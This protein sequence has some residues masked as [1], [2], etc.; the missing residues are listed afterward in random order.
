M[1]CPDCN[2]ELKYKMTVRIP[3]IKIL[4]LYLCSKCNRMKHNSEKI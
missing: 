3:N 2:T 4:F 1:R